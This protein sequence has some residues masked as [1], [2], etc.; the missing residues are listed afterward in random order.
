V[1]VHACIGMAGIRRR[2]EV[3]CLEEE[4]FINSHWRCLRDFSCAD[5]RLYA[6][7]RTRGEFSWQSQNFM[8]LQAEAP[9]G[10][11]EAVFDR[12]L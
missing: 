11:F 9:S 1:P 7:A 6:T 3:C 10:V 5:Q 4:L 8:G 2:Q 12:G